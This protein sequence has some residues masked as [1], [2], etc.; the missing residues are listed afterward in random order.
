MVKTI[1]PDGTYSETEY[2]SLGQ[3]QSG[4]TGTLS[5][6]ATLDRSGRRTEF[7]YD[8]FG[9]TISTTDPK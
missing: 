8:I 1:M 2:N 6:T 7:V 5:P 9:R 4:T 3:P